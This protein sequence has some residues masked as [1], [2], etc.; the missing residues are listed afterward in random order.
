MKLKDFFG[1]PVKNKKSGQ[2]NASIKK[3]SLKKLGLTEEELF[4]MEIS[5]K[6]KPKNK[7]GQFQPFYL[8]MIAVIIFILAF[9]LITPLTNSSN[10][11]RTGVYNNVTIGLD[12]SNSSIPYYQQITC[13]VVDIIPAW[14]IALILSLGGAAFAAKFVL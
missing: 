5:E 1:K 2:T 14:I 4:N 11:V 7:K 9:A 6:L 13:T 8:F 12:C 10:Q 3:T